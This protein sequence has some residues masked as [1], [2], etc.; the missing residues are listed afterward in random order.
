MYPARALQGVMYTWTKNNPEQ[1]DKPKGLACVSG[2]QSK[3]TKGADGKWVAPHVLCPVHIGWH[4]KVLQARDAGVT[5]E[6]LKAP[7]F[8]KVAQLEKVPSGATV[9]V[10]KEARDAVAAKVGR[11]VLVITREQ[12]RQGLM[13]DGSQ[14]FVLNGRKFHPMVRGV[15][16]RA[17]R[18]RVCGFRVGICHGRDAS[19]PHA[20]AD[21]EQEGWEGGDP[22]GDHRAAVKSLAAHHD[23]YAP[24]ATWGADRGGCG[25]R[26]VGG[27]RHVPHVH[28]IA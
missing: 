17:T 23:G 20:D 15:W 7:V 9:V 4:A 8:S 24:F 3:V 6:V 12:E 22:C 19:D 5:V 2:C 10:D 25:E 21:C 16:I 28:P 1:R 18:Q 11:L 27:C 26:R 14:P 13:Y